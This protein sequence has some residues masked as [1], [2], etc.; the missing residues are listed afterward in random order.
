MQAIKLMI[1]Q[2]LSLVLLISAAEDFLER[3]TPTILFIVAFLV[4]SLCSIYINR[5]E[6][7]LLKEIDLFFKKKE[8]EESV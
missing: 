1:A 7:E 2:M 3:T 4:F 5:H 8:L 6:K